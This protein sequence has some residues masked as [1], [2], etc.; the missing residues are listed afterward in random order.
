[1]SVRERLRDLDW[2]DFFVALVVSSIVGIPFVF[3]ST[4]VAGVVAGVVVGAFSIAAL[5]YG[6]VRFG[7]ELRRG[8]SEGKR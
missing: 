3:F 7:S 8:W 1:M 4:T 2:R 6:V 5:T